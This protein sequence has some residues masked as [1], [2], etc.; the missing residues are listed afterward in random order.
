[1]VRVGPQ[2]TVTGTY[3]AKQNVVL[4]TPPPTILAALADGRVVTMRNAPPFTIFEAW[5]PDG[6]PPTATA[7]VPGLY[8]YAGGGRLASDVAPADD[9]SLSVL[10]NSAT[11]GDVVLQFGPGLTPRWLYRYPRIVQNS[12]LV[13]GDDQG[14]VYY[15]DPL[16]NEIVAL[17]RF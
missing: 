5:P 17:R 16:N 7:Q 3:L 9:G 14:T 11:L 2:G 8:V 4:P 10:L 6:S 1:V 13:A 15:V 12:S